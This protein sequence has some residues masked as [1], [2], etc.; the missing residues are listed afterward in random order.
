V[1]FLPKV[2]GILAALFDRGL[3]RGCGGAAGLLKSA[4]VETVLS[5][6][7]APIMMLIQSRF[8]ADIVRGRD[9]GWSAQNR[10]ADALPWSTAL[11]LHAGHTIVGLVLA[12]A[13]FSASW[14][15]LLWLSPIILGLVFSAPLSWLTAQ[16]RASAWARRRG[17][18][19]IPEEGV[20]PDS[21]EAAQKRP[22]S[23]PVSLQAGE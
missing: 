21:P 2:L 9:S 3:R 6:L 15:T 7:I 10:G 14:E 20:G 1:L 16:A 8:V 13:A 5:A 11:K 4:L 18:F 19:L 17:F 23:E 22:E 12:A